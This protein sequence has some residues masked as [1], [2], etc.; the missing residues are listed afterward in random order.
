[1]NLDQSAQTEGNVLADNVPAIQVSAERTASA[2]NV[3]GMNYLHFP[4]FSEVLT[5]SISDY[6]A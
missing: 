1:M 2:R 5:A 6:L 4:F 3:P